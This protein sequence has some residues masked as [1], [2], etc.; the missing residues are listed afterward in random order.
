MNNNEKGFSLIE[1]LLVVVIIGIV[2]AL[3]V[4]A[5]QKGIWAAENGNAFAAMRTLNSTQV[6]FFSQNSRFG[7][8][9]EVNRMIGGGIG[10]EVGDRL[11][12]G[13]YVFEMGPLVPTPEELRTGFKIIATRSVPGEITYQYELDQSGE[14]EQIQP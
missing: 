8:L 5:F 6:G 4:P 10:T 12:R 3:A 14:I 2:A 1:L 9:A 7:S 13:K 11:V